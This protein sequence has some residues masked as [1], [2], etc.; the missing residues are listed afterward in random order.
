MAL[1]VAKNKTGKSWELN[2]QLG[3]DKGT[4]NSQT[5]FATKKFTTHIGSNKINVHNKSGV[6]LYT[7]V[8]NSGILP[9]GKEITQQNGLSIKTN[10]SNKGNTI[11]E[12]LIKQGTAF[13][14]T[15][16]VTNTTQS[17]IENVALTQFIPS[18]WEIINTRYN[19]YETEK[20]N[21]DYLDIRDDRAN[22][23]FSLKAQE[24]K[25]F[26]I[27]LNASYKGTYYLSGTFAEAMYNVQYNT[28]NAGKWIKVE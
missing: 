1:Y 15:I 9:V 23:Y 12:D 6:T 19:N 28:R 4:V 2:Y 18:G 26:Q 24:T 10:F 13:V 11:S 25:Q 27:K 7:R 8:I 21:Y 5:G 20:S 3:K 22:F 14:C 16:S 17:N